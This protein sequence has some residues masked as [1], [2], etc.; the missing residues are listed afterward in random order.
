MKQE[1]GGQ[2]SL[3]KSG[4]LYVSQST[5]GNNGFIEVIFHTDNA[6]NEANLSPVSEE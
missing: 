3:D 1:T 6:T 4:I 5:G 2:V